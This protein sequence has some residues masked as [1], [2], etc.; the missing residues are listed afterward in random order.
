METYDLIYFPTLSGRI[1]YK[2][3]L[4][5]KFLIQHQRQKKFY[6]QAE[7]WG[8]VIMKIFVTTGTSSF[9]FKRLIKEVLEIAKDKYFINDSF[10][11]S[12]D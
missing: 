9:P 6:P 5:D 4:F 8:K 12:R 2:L 7:Y 11:I 3:K 1:I 10:L